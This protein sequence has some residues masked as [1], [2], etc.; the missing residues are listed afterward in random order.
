VHLTDAAE[1]NR[2]SDNLDVKVLLI[3]CVAISRSPNVRRSLGRVE[4]AD[5]TLP[6]EYDIAFLQSLRSLGQ[7]FVNIVVGQRNALMTTDRQRISASILRAG[8]LGP[9]QQ[10][11]PCDSDDDF[12]FHRTH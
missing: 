11:K 7:D 10:A 4:G 12:H 3:D 2:E 6:F 1:I 8:W 5:G 9:R